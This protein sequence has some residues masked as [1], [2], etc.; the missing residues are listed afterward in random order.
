MDFATIQAMEMAR[1]LALA[2]PPSAEQLVETIDEVDGYF[3]TA[4]SH[5]ISQGA[6]H[7]RKSMSTL[8]TGLKVAIRTP[9]AHM[10]SGT[11]LSEVSCSPVTR[12]RR[13]QALNNTFH[14]WRR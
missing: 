4:T 10:A 14:R 8:L 9:M 5:R 6:D 13:V 1:K 7:T 12:A 3:M 2:M 11:K